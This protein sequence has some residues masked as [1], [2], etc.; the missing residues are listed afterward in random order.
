MEF[1]ANI[2]GSKAQTENEKARIKIE[3]E[4]LKLE[5]QKLEG[6]KQDDELDDGVVII[7]DT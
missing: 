7:N 4:K 6:K 2:T 5:K 3:K 1:I